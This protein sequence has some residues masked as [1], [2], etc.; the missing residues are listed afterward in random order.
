MLHGGSVPAPW[1]A[2]EGCPGAVSSGTPPDPVPTRPAEPTTLDSKTGGGATARTPG[3]RDQILLTRDAARRLFEAHVA[4]AKA[5]LAPIIE[6]IKGVAAA[7]GI[8]VALA[9]FAAVLGTIG[10]TLFLGEWFFGSMGWGLVHGLALSVAIIAGA[11]A[12]IVLGSESRIGRGIVLGIVVG[13]LLGIVFYLNLTHAAWA[14]LADSLDMS[15]I[16]ERWRTVV[17]A[18]GVSAAVLAV[19]G[20]IVGVGAGRSFGSL[21]GGLLVG[22]LVGVLVGAF[23]AITF[24]IEVAVA[25]GILAAY[26]TFSVFIFS[27]IARHGVDEAALKSRFVPEQTIATTRETLEWLQS[28]TPGGNAP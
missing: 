11:V 23:T 4:L 9:L 2:R 10:T 5:E 25:L 7:A 24:S 8:A 26:I 6:N 3:L 19:V 17:A 12:Y 14:A 27:W 20:A 28:Q 1:R 21:V 15:G 22:A 13:L 18:I 16:E